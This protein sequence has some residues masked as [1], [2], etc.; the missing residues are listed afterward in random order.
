MCNRVL[1][2]IPREKD[3]I[4]TEGCQRDIQAVWYRE[5]SSIM[6]MVAYK[7]IITSS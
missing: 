7:W 1:E 3:K 2:Q 5:I 4:S 6:D